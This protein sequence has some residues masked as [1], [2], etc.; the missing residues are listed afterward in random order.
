MKSTY[1]MLPSP[2]NLLR[3][4]VPEEDKCQCGQY[5]TMR[6]ILSACP[7]GLKDRCTW[8]H[9]QV[10]RVIVDAMETK[11]NEINQGRLPMKECQGKVVFHQKE[12]KSVTQPPPKKQMV[13]ERWQGSWKMAADLD[14][15][16]VFPIVTTSQRPDI[17]VWSDDA[18]RVILLELT[19]IWEENFG[20]ADD[21]KAKRYEEL[22]NACSEGGW[23]PEYYH[24]AAGC[25]GYV[26]R[27][28]VNIVRDRYGL[29]VKELKALTAALQQAAEIASYFIWLKRGDKVW[30]D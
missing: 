14:S 21:W 17:V 15:S 18:R 27:D 30:L 2:A 13:D 28:L 10:I 23:G 26:S 8:R 3:W 11:V 7:L 6:H 16:L 19:V 9:N 29:T 12:K 4:E 24:L 22:V 25:R 1:D 20:D 5:G